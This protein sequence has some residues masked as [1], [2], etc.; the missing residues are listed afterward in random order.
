LLWHPEGLGFIL[1]NL[2]L[3]DAVTSLLSR[4]IAQ[5][6]GSEDLSALIKY[7]RLPAS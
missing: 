5:G 4:A 3:G 1:K 6:Y 2:E 7:M